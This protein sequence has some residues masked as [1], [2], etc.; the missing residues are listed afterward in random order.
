MSTSNYYI[1]KLP[2]GLRKAAAHR[3]TIATEVRGAGH[4]PGRKSVSDPRASLDGSEIIV[5]CDGKPPYPVQEGPM[6][7]HEMRQYLR[8]HNAAWADE[9]TE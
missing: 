6:D 3:S 5:Q 9:E 4:P 7:V 8:D 2:H 1:C